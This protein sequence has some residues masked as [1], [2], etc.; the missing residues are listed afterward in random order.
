MENS[1]TNF[2]THNKATIRQVWPKDRH[3]NQGNRSES[4]ELN[5]Y[6]GLTDIWLRYQDY[7]LETEQSFQQTGA[8]TNGYSH[9]KNKAITVLHIT[10][11][12]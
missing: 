5:S 9:A 4:P 8:V 2:K 11:K 10:Y 1:L 6:L 7:S 3:T 12:N